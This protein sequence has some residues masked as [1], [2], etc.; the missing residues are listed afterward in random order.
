[1]PPRTRRVHLDDAAILADLQRTFRAELS[2]T[3]PRR[4]ESYYTVEGQIASI[5]ADLDRYARAE[6]EPR[7]ILDDSGIVVGRVNLFFIVRG[8]LQSCTL[9]YWVSPAAA[10]RGL[11][12]SAV[13]HLAAWAFDGL[14]LHRIEAGTL[15]DNAASQRVLVKNGFERFGLAPR[16]LRVDGRWQDHVL[17]QRLNEDWS[18][19][20]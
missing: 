10:G 15:V 4:A 16:L 11:A 18:E 17:F 9:G 7:V 2:A 13:A 12:T 8:P 20:A 5:T 3:E 1:M 14:G 6:A 19:R